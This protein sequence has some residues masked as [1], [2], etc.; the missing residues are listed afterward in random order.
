MLFSH[1]QNV[2]DHFPCLP[3]FLL[4]NAKSKSWSRTDEICPRDRYVKFKNN[5]SGRERL[6][7]MALKIFVPRPLHITSPDHLVCTRLNYSTGVSGLQTF[8]PVFC[9]YN[10][11][12]LHAVIIYKQQFLHSDW[13]RACQLIPNQCKKVK[14]SAKRW[15]WVQKSEIECKTVKLKW[16]TART[17][18]SDKQNGGQKLNKDCNS[19]SK[20]QHIYF[21]TKQSAKLNNNN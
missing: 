19:S 15:N 18:S 2:K 3:N 10:K 1:C 8:K 17:L 6:W 12:R 16:L 9:I 21:I 20:F 4:L 14:L 7:D 13:L 11:F 5:T